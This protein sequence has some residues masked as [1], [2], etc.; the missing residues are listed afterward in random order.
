MSVLCKKYVNTVEQEFFT[1]KLFSRLGHSADTGMGHTGS[2]VF[3]LVTF[4]DTWFGYIAPTY[5][6]LLKDNTVFLL[7][8]NWL[9]PPGVSAPVILLLFT[10]G[11]VNISLAVSSLQVPVIMECFFPAQATG[12]ALAQVLTNTG[13]FSNP[14][15]RLPFTWPQSAQQV[16]CVCNMCNMCVTCV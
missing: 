2:F 13:Q 7:I 10:A 1:D 16:M 6:C 4:T 5:I 9:C 15:G 8:S 11:P 3:W 12:Q 14:A